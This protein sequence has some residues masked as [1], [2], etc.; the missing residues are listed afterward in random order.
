MVYS[1]R[2]NVLTARLRT[3]QAAAATF[4]RTRT[5]RTR[6]EDIG[7][8]FITT[9]GR[10]PT[11]DRSRKPS[12]ITVD[13]VVFSIT[14]NLPPIIFGYSARTKDAS[15]TLA[16]AH[17]KLRQARLLNRRPVSA[18]RGRGQL[19]LWRE[20]RRRAAASALRPAAT[21]AC[22]HARNVASLATALRGG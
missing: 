12:G 5:G 13:D 3:F 6:E 8:R 18:A 4:S 1:R 15:T 9:K 16:A 7:S 17:S 21:S 14:L 11:E 2:D 22:N 20:C 10:M 19:G